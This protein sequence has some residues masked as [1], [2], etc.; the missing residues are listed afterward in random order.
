MKKLLVLLVMFTLL[1]A[2]DKVALVIGNKSYINQTGLK[3]PIRDAKLIRD[4]LHDMGF[5][6]VEA[7]DKN[8]NDLSTK[9]DVFIGKA[10][11]AKIAVVYYAGHGIGVGSRN[12]LIP[13][14]SANLS[15]DNLGRKLMSVNELKGAVAK[16]SAFGVVFFDACR[17]SLFSGSI[18]GL[19]NRGNRALV[20]PTVSTTQNILV[21]FSTQAGK[22]AKDDVNNGDHSPYAMALSENLLSNSNIDIRRMM[23]SVRTRVLGLTNNQQYPIDENQLQGEEYCLKGL[24]KQQIVRVVDNSENERLRAKIALLEQKKNVYVA[25][26]TLVK[27][28]VQIVHTTNGITQIGNLMY[29]NQAF[30][31]TYTWEEAGEYCQGLRLGNYSDWRLPTRDELGKIG[32]IKLNIPWKKGW[33]DKNK[34]RRLIG[35]KG[36]NLFVRQEFLENMQTENSPWFWTSEE[37]D[38]SHAWLVLFH[39]GSDSWYVKT[40]NSY[41]LCVR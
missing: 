34:H 40:G 8:L 32:N 4:T 21:S 31:K 5:E 38:S 14:G 19:T 28:P 23:G 39:F 26:E 33:Y 12:Y 20:Q 37:K 36:R 15:V 22:L 9:L 35:S 16:A 7:Y 17:N 11:N 3:N 13:L 27:K 18:S 29:Q 6:V 25:P 2:S 41:A 30:I 1:S 10:R 24:C